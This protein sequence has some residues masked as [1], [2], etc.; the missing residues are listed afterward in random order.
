MTDYMRKLI[1]AAA[2]T[3][4]AASVIGAAMASMDARGAGDELPDLFKNVL[5]GLNRAN[6]I[7]DVREDAIAQFDPTRIIMGFEG[8]APMLVPTA[9][10]SVMWQRPQ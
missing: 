1:T 5:D 8:A 10:R 7:A 6:D 9:Q 4:A 2:T 3:V